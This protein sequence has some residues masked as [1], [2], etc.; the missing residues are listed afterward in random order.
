MGSMCF[1][2]ICFLPR[3]V[4]HETF[5]GLVKGM[6]FHKIAGLATRP[7]NNGSLL[8]LSTIKNKNG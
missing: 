3:R 1:R 6:D 5:N 8:A 7:A 2:V 4:I